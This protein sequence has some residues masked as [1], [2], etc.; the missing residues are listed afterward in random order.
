MAKNKWIHRS[1]LMG[2]EL[3][4]VSDYESYG[5]S[6]WANSDNATALARE[7]LTE[8]RLHVGEMAFQTLLDEFR[9]NPT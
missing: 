2:T 3:H 8:V 9:V 7:V 5:F 6:L 4:T 1:Y